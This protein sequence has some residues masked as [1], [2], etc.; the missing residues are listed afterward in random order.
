MLNYIIATAAPFGLRL[1]P[2]K[3]ELICFHRPGTVDKNLLPVV[4][5]G[6][7]IL[8][9]KSSVVYLG[10]RVAEDGSTLAAIK[11]RICCA[12]TVVKRLNRRVFSRRAITNHLKGN[13]IES[14]VFASLL[15]GLEHCAFGV[16][17][18]RCLDGFFLRLAKRVMHL[19]Y[20]YHLSYVEAERRLGV[21]RPSTR[22]AMERLRWTGHMLRSEDI[23][24]FEAATF[25]PPGGARGRGRPRRRYMDTIKADLKNR[26]IDVNNNLDNFWANL[27]PLAANRSEWSEIVKGDARMDS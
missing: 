8:D 22:L 21:K 1:S 26:D 19:R 13:F 7:K 27:K 17:D 6:N 5:I 15:Y 4:R 23:V 10:S 20:D 14:A 9:W 12:E 3:C 16:R 11:H 25:V 24:L 2:A 18:R